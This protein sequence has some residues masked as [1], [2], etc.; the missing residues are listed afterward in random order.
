M[1]FTPHILQR[2]IVAHPITDEFGR[3]ID[4]DSSTDWETVCNC[5][6]DDNT[7]TE[8]RSDNGDVYRPQYHVVCSG[9]HDLKAGEYVQCIE[10]DSVRGEGEIVRVLKTNYFNFTEVYL[11]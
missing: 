8:F 11:R 2:K 4:S 1:I 10:G 6:C 9:K 3:V 7:T 5:R